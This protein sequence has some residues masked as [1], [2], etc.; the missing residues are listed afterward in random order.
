MRSKTPPTSSCRRR[1][2]K[3]QQVDVSI[4]TSALLLANPDLFSEILRNL[5]ENAIKYTPAGGRIALAC[6]ET[7][8]HIVITVA[9]NGIGIAQSDLPRI[10]D[11]FYRVDKARARASG[12]NGIGL[13]LVKYLVKLFGGTITVESELGKGTRFT[14]TFPKLQA[15]AS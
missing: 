2:K 10:F 11:R 13:A 3:Q 7:A 8:H 15:S 5:I 12:G 6:T 14:L 1:K 9:D 4:E